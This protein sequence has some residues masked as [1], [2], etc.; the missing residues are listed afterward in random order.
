M[1]LSPTSGCFIL[2]SADPRPVP[3]ELLR[4]GR[5]LGKG[6]CPGT[7]APAPWIHCC[8]FCCCQ[9]WAAPRQVS[10]G[11]PQTPGGGRHLSG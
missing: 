11:R 10:G 8:C 3:L 7:R 9:L 6:S 4:L 1:V 2:K 5:G